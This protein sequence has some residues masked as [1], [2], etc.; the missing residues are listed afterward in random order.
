M[1]FLCV[2]SK[3]LFNQFLFKDPETCILQY[4]RDSLHKR[5]RQDKCPHI[6]SENEPVGAAPCSGVVLAADA[7]AQPRLR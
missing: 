4:T 5:H 2:T 3:H 6:I 7:C 1:L